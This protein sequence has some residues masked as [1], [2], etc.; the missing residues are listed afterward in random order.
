MY[1]YI[2]LLKILQLFKI[3]SRY[4]VIYNDVMF[5]VLEYCIFNNQ[6]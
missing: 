1:L 6:R 2:Q 3:D 4:D 5:N